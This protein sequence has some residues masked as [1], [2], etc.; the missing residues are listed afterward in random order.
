MSTPVTVSDLAQL[1]SGGKPVELFEPIDTGFWIRV[2][3]D[4]VCA[5]DQQYHP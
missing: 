1:V 3:V 2:H 4:T 5:L